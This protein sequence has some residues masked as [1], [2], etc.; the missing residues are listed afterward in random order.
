MRALLFATS[1]TSAPHFSLTAAPLYR[2]NLYFLLI[3]IVAS[4][5]RSHVYC[6]F[7]QNAS[8]ENVI[9]YILSVIKNKIRIRLK[10]YLYF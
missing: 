5:S 8:I 2:T 3:H 7:T 1:A 9:A 4:S 6:I 10:K